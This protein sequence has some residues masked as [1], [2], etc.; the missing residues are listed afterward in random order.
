MCGL[1]PAHAGRTRRARQWPCGRRAHPRS[2]GENEELTLLADSTRGSSP[3][4]R[5]KRCTHGGRGPGHGLIPTHT[6]KTRLPAHSYAWCRAHPR[7]GGKTVFRPRA[8]AS[9]PAHPRTRGE[10][11]LTPSMVIGPYGSCPLTRGRR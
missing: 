1:I 5:G 3:L 2:R 10:N 6:G 11:C 7:S 4:T 9:R 8:H